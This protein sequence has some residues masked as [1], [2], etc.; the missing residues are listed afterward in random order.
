M[1]RHMS[2]A[3]SMFVNSEEIIPEAINTSRKEL[4]PSSVSQDTSTVTKTKPHKVVSTK[5]GPKS[6]QGRLDSLLVKIKSKKVN[7]WIIAY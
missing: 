5:V 3:H 7:V 4:K 6:K 1:Q 2:K